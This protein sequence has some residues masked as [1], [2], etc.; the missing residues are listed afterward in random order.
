M[1]AGKVSTGML[2]HIDMNSAGSL[3][4]SPADAAQHAAHQKEAC[5]ALIQALMNAALDRPPGEPATGFSQRMGQAAVNV[6]LKRD[7]RPREVWVIPTPFRVFRSSVCGQTTN[8]AGYDFPNAKQAHASQ[9]LV[10]DPAAVQARVRQHTPDPAAFESKV[11]SM[12]AAGC[13][14]VTWHPY[15]AAPWLRRPNIDV[16]HL[17]P[18]CCTPSN[19]RAVQHLPSAQAH[20]VL[21]R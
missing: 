18:S 4:P 12:R 2:R 1:V 20:G 13:V 14:I 10:Q 7:T 17:H 3:A 9:L 19:G 5:I 16:M 11:A 6:L 8:S 15:T 21:A